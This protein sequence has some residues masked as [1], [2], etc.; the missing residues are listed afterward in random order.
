[1]VPKNRSDYDVIPNEIKEEYLKTI[2]GDDENGV[3]GIGMIGDTFIIKDPVWKDVVVDISITCSKL[4]SDSDIG[5]GVRQEIYDK[6]NSKKFAE[7]LS[8]SDIYDSVRSVDGVMKIRLNKL[9]ERGNDDVNEIECDF[10][11]IIRVRLEDI[12]VNVL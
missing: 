4:F 11:E 10:N 6:L 1:M 2:H 12:V 3:D 8:I 9:C 7:E 5:N